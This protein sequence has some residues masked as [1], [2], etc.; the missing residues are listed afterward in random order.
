M[1]KTAKASGHISFRLPVES[2]GQLQEVARHLGL[3]LTALLNLI[4]HEALPGYLDKASKLARERAR[5][6]AALDEAVLSAHP[7]VQQLVE[8]GRGR[9]RANA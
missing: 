2:H 3:D 4:I 1:A 6:G 7:L 8:V 9:T 5:A